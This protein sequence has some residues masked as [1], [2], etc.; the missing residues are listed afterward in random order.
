M[1][2]DLRLTKRYKYVSYHN[3]KEKLKMKMNVPI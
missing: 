1:I 3:V 2:N